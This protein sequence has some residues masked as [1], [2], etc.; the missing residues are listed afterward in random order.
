MYKIISFSKKF[1]PTILKNEKIIK[2]YVD[3][4]I[5]FFEDTNPH[6]VFESM[7]IHISKSKYFPT[8]SELMDN[9]KRAE[10]VLDSRKHDRE[11]Q[12]VI[13]DPDYT[14]ESDWIFQAGVKA[15]F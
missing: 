14:L 9:L 1:F 8:V 4:Y 6:L 2:D 3:A 7:K 13:S 10:L 15:G 5:P 12:S 11:H